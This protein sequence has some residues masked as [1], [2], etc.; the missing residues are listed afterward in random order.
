MRVL[1]IAARYL[2]H[3]GG[4]ETVV[5][6]LAQELGHSGHAVRIVTNRYP[7]RLRSVETIDGIR[8]DRLFFIPPRLDYLRQKRFD[9]FMAS[10]VLSCGTVARL[11][12]LTRTFQP[13]VINLHY[14]GSPSLYT[15]AVSALTSVPV[16]A[17]LHGGDV[18]GEP[19]LSRFGRWQFSATV[20]RARLVTAC[21]RWLAGRVVA[22]SPASAGKIRVIH[23][24]VNL[25]TFRGAAPYRHRQPYILA[26]GQLSNHKGFE[27][28]IDAFS[29][30]TGRFPRVDLLIA[31]DGACRPALECQAERLGLR[32][33]VYFLGSRAEPEVASLMAGSEFIV[34]PSRREPF[35]IVALEGMAAGRP[36]LASPVGGLPE[37]AF[38][39][40]NRLVPLEK[41]AWASAMCELLAADA[42]AAVQTDGCDEVARFS[43]EAV[44]GHYLAVYEEAILAHHATFTKPEMGLPPSVSTQAHT[45]N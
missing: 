30:I 16:V 6:H 24:G 13:D 1:I 22:L 27:F 42:E 7:R 2:P 36:V 14:A 10:P 40:P 15:L 41:Q 28:M 9:L 5:A 33:S 45:R 18:D 39:H 11:Y 19:Q 12:W 29:S 3:R 17:S 23:N 25:K 8:V 35:G 38:R 20:G 43:W 21:S 34:M 44:T 32:H 37:L 4:L 26:V 31:G